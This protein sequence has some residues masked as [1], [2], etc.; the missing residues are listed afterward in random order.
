MRGVASNTMICTRARMRARHELYNRSARTTPGVAAAA[1]AEALVEVE[2][3]LAEGG[4][5][6]GAAADRVNTNRAYGAS[7]NA[8]SSA[9]MA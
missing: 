8:G 6:A 3:A 9:E 4:S 1:E 5:R 7:S 2:V